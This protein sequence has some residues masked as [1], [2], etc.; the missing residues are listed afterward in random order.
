M[1]RTLRRRALPSCQSL[2]AF[3]AAARHLSFS[4][5]SDELH[6]TQGAISQ[7]VKM[8][9]ERLGAQLFTRR[10]RSIG[11][12]AAGHFLYQPIRS[13]LQQMEDIVDS[14]PELADDELV[15]YAPPCMGSKWLMP[16]IKEFSQRHAKIRLRLSIGAKPVEIPSKVKHVSITIGPD[17]SGKDTRRDFLRNDSIFPV[18]SP[19]L[20]PSGSRLSDI[21][22][23]KRFE[24]LEV[25]DPD[26]NGS[27]SDWLSWLSLCGEEMR[28]QKPMLRF[29][30]SLLAIQAAI[31]GSGIALARGLAAEPDLLSGSLVK[32]LN[33]EVNSE[34]AYYFVYSRDLEGC[35]EVAC[36]REW[37]FE[38]VGPPARV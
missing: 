30:D 5:A 11:L 3:E 18:C 8:L 20:L 6:L 10:P 16:R 23:L 32:P 9:E 36:F 22:D 34:H 1:T 26:G 31:A 28:P 24:L 4:R 29:G 17:G 14:V 35:D 27:G 12:T 13:L 15:V 25:S 19:R 33:V 7:Q 21:S 38:V 2:Q 37:L